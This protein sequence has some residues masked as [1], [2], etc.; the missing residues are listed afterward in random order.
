[1]YCQDDHDAGEIMMSE[2]EVQ[3]G[4]LAATLQVAVPFWIEQLRGAGDE[5]R[6]AMA[7]ESAQFIAEHG[8]N[9]LYRGAR[10]GDSAKAFNH[11]ARGLAIGAYQPGGVTAFGQHWEA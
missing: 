5:D 11:V 4:L 3:A 6:L 8:D 2:D 9:V 10:K 7:L 1:V